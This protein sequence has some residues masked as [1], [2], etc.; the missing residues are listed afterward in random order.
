[1]QIKKARTQNRVFTLGTSPICQRTH[2]GS[3]RV[4]QIGIPLFKGTLRIIQSVT[5][6]SA[7]PIPFSQKS[8]THEE[9]QPQIFLQQDLVQ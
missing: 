2:F 8:L 7:Q 6:K 3:K 1:M 9:R 4:S 5:A